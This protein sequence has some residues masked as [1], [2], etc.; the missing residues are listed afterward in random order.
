LNGIKTKEDKLIIEEE[1][2]RKEM[3][4][5]YSVV[6]RE[7]LDYADL[8]LNEEDRNAQYERLKTIEKIKIRI[9]DS[10]AGNSSN[11]RSP[12]NSP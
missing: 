9:E 2:Y 12:D 6:G 8:I 4:Q 7:A 1:S 11:N 10:G 5:A 3:Q